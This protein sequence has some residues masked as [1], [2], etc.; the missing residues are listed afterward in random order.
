M[1]AEIDPSSEVDAYSSV[2]P[3]KDAIAIR[4][5]RLNR[6]VTVNISSHMLKPTE[7]ST[8]EIRAIL[9]EAVESIS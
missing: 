8:G 4:I 7:N 1:V 5:R 2:L 3:E 9:K 6:T